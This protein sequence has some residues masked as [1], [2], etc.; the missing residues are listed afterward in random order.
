MGVLG[1]LIAAKR[2]KLIPAVKVL[3]DDLIAQVG[4]RVSNKL[5]IDVLQAVGE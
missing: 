2:R 1:T 4:F 3:M 5:Y